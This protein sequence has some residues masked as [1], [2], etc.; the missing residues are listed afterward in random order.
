MNTKLTVETELA[1]KEGLE[2]FT[3]YLVK[4]HEIFLDQQQILDRYE[5]NFGEYTL[6][7][8]LAYVIENPR[9]Q[10]MW[11]KGLTKVVNFIVGTK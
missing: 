2:G 10:A 11:K 5:P 9:P 6:A 8:F 3:R 4:E 1:L 7:Q